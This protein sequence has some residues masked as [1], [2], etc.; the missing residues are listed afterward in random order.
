MVQ[1]TDYYTDKW[2]RSQDFLIKPI[3]LSHEPAINTIASRTE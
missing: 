3:S 1:V 2:G